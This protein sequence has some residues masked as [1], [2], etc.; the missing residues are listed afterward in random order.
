MGL[1]CPGAFPVM[2]YAT[3]NAITTSFSDLIE[4][5]N[6]PLFI[7]QIADVLTTVLYV[8]LF[9]FLNYIIII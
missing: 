8:W 4:P 6:N 3:P 1:S 9:Y 5:R 7:T 2:Q